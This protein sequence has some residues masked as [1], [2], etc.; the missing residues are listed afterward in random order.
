MLDLNGCI[1]ISDQTLSKFLWKE[2][3]SLGLRNI[4]NISVEGLKR[5]CINCPSIEQLDLNGCSSIDDECVEVITKGLSNLKD[6]D[7]SG[8]SITVKGLDHISNN[9]FKIKVSICIQNL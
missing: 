7:L 3:L 1:N 4:T 8:T 6:I 2:L 5:L 9:C